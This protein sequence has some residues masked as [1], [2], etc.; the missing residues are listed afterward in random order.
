MLKCLL[1]WERACPS[2]EHLGPWGRSCLYLGSLSSG[3]IFLGIRS[4]SLA[5]LGS[6]HFYCLWHRKWGEERDSLEW[7]VIS[8]ISESLNLK[9]WWCI[10][11]E[12]YFW[13][14]KLLLTY[15]KD[16]TNVQTL[17]PYN[18]VRNLSYGNYP[19]SRKTGNQNSNNNNNKKGII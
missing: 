4:R 6:W 14:Q 10:W 18:S 3:N 17:W 1:L 15:L 11:M 13:L 12:I 2:T 16:H 9:W 8:S 19:K 5:S 7:V